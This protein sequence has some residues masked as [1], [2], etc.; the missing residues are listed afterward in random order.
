MLRRSHRGSALRAPFDL[1]VGA[2]AVA[3]WLVLVVPLSR[4]TRRRGKPRILWAP[5]PIPNIIYSARADRLYG[6][7]SRTL[8]F[9]VYRISDRAQFDHPLDRFR[10]VRVAGRLVPY[11]AFLWAGLRTDVYGFFF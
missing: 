9:D 1:V 4:L 3:L 10:R 2:I 7:E 8:V 6:Y 11:V 5:I